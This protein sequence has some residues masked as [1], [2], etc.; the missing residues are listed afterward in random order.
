MELTDC[1]TRS[2]FAR[3]VGGNSVDDLKKVP[4]GELFAKAQAMGVNTN[5]WAERV[6]RGHGVAILKRLAQN[7]NP[8]PDEFHT[9]IIT[10]LKT[11]L[12]GAP[13]VHAKPRAL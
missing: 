3:F 10:A 6:G 11:I 2:E 4:F 9:D 12:N 7:P 8:P 5:T 1:K 13:A